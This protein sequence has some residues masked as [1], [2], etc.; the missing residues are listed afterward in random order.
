MT[1]QLTKGVALG[2]RSALAADATLSAFFGPNIFTMSDE[3]TRVCDFRGPT[4]IVV[5][6]DFTAGFRSADRGRLRLRTSI[7]LYM[8]LS[9]PSRPDLARA[10]KPTLTQPDAGALTGTYKYVVTRTYGGGESYAFAVDIDLPGRVAA[11]NA[12]SITVV[13]KKIHVAVGSNPCRLWRTKDGGSCYFYRATLPTGGAIDDEALDDTLGYEIAP[14]AL[15]R[16]ELLQWVTIALFVA[17]EMKVGTESFTPNNMIPIGVPE[18]LMPDRNLVLSQ[19]V[20]DYGSFFRPQTGA[21]AVNLG[22]PEGE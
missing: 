19:I 13:A 21:P 17:G 8:P 20:A 7:R 11:D 9:T 12:S 16:E 3:E 2:I 1:L 15:L 5:P 10:A 6:G 4:L 14:E 22:A 18:Q